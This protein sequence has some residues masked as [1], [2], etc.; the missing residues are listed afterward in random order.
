MAWTPTAKTLMRGQRQF[1]LSEVVAH[2]LVIDRISRR[3]AK[4]AP[5]G[6]RPLKCDLQLSG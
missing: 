5:D 1:G 4:H 2:G 6:C 3:D